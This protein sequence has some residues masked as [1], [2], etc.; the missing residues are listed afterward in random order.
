MFLVDLI[1][2][3]DQCRVFVIGGGSIPQ[4]CSIGYKPSPRVVDNYRTPCWRLE[5]DTLS[6][7][8]AVWTPV[9]STYEARRFSIHIQCAI[10]MALHTGIKRSF[11]DMHASRSHLS[12]SV[13]RANSRASSPQHGQSELYRQSMCGL[14]LRSS[15][16]FSLTS[17]QVLAMGGQ[18]PQT[19]LVCS[20]KAHSRQMPRSYS[21]EYEALARAH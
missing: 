7:N 16:I 3:S 6:S 10:M 15:T 20:G 9:E 19:P 18:L 17:D 14:R 8:N 11:D 1:W 21:L 13:S 4:P 5:R 2:L 12:E